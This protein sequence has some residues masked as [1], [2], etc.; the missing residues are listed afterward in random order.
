MQ[1]A[2][3]QNVSTLCRSELLKQ[4]VSQQSIEQQQQLGRL[5]PRTGQPA[6]ASAAKLIQA[7]HD[8]DAPGR[9]Q[10]GHQG[11]GV[12]FHTTLLLS[13]CH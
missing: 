7:V 4:Q 6:A 10:T 12:L 9:A 5:T 8:D 13:S 11:V 3:S 1:E 2:A